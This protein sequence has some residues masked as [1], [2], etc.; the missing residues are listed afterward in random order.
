MLT[1]TAADLA[2]AAEVFNSLA[3]YY[4]AFTADFKYES[5]MS[6]V[7]AW[8]QA[9]GLRGRQ[10]LDA[11]C[12]TGNSFMPMLDRGYEIVACDISPAMVARAREKAA[13]RAEVVVADLRALPWRDR[14]D[15]VTCVDEPMNYLLTQEDLVRAMT[16]IGRALRP[17]GLAVLDFNSLAAFRTDFA[18]EF[19][20][21]SQGTTFRWRG[22]ASRHMPPGSLASTTI[23]R[24][25]PG[26]RPV[27]IGRH[28][29][30]HHSVEAVAK[31]CTEAGI[32]LLET[33]GETPEAGLVPGP[34]ESTH[35]RFACIAQR[36]RR[37]RVACR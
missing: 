37:R 36:P 17:G 1:R 20:I 28:V 8:A 33:R 32:E 16:C 3:P 14:F 11:A 34:D 29:Q 31:A 13:G 27:C 26:G 18:D 2:T 12:G 30:R 24:L 35:L 25:S 4:D 19:T 7:D 22:E 5:W 9:H 6:D 15:L 10:L 21:E 23:E